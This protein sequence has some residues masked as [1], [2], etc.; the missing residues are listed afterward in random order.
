M[1]EIKATKWPTTEISRQ[2]TRPERWGDSKDGNTSAI[3]HLFIYEFKDETNAG[4]MMTKKMYNA[5]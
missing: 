4:S 3:I 2:I 5:M 1:T